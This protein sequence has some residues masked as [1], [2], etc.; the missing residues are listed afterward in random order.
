VSERPIATEEDLRRA[1]WLAFALDTWGERELQGDR[2]NPRILTWAR[3]LGVADVYQHDAQA[4][5]ALWLSWC[6]SGAYRRIAD[7]WRANLPAGATCLRAAAFRSWGRSLPLTSSARGAIAVVT[8]PIGK[9]HVAFLWSRD[10]HGFIDLLGG[11]QS[12]EVNLAGYSTSTHSSRQLVDLRW[13]LGFP[14][15]EA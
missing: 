15:P 14:L 8:R 10:Q 6:L 11:N 12:D 1:P 5:C 7:D 9:F 13:P 4:W 2:D 3:D